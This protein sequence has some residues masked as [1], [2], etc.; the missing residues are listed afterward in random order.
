MTLMR[1]RNLPETV[2]PAHL[3][4]HLPPAF[5]ATTVT[6]VAVLMTFLARALTDVLVRRFTLQME[7]L[8]CVAPRAS[9]GDETETTANTRMA[10]MIEVTIRVGKDVRRTRRAV[11]D[12][13]DTSG[14]QEPQLQ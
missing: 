6:L 3:I 11:G 4:R 2:F 1:N 14:W 13:G 10:D 9:S 8:D 12:K 7:T 5:V